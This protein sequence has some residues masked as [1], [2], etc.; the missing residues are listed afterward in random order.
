MMME[1]AKRREKRRK[2]DSQCIR[3][4]HGLLFAMKNTV[5]ISALFRDNVDVMKNGQE[6]RFL[7]RDAESGRYFEVSDIVAQ[8]KVGQVNFPMSVSVLLIPARQIQ[9]VTH[10]YPFVH[11]WSLTGN[12]GSENEVF[13]N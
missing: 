12:Q 13:E 4:Q 8:A 7:K 11:G 3:S 2:N 1:Q 9:Q 10:F 5:M 6:R